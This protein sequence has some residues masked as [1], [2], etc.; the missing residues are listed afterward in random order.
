MECPKCKNIAYI[1]DDNT[2]KDDKVQFR[3]GKLNCGFVF[4]VHL[5]T[6]DRIEAAK[7]AEKTFKII[8]D[9]ECNFPEWWYQYIGNN[10]GSESSYRDDIESYSKQ[11]ELAFA[12]VLKGNNDGMP[13]V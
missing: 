3:C 8:A 5:L 6:P 12:P 4:F 10:D 11:H 9:V 2:A 7:V 13:E 1:A